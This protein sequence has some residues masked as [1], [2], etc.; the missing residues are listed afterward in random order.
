MSQN[1]FR[2]EVAQC[3]K[4]AKKVCQN[5][6][7]I[8]LW[9]QNLLLQSAED[10]FLKCRS[11]INSA[12][13]LFAF[14]K[15]KLQVWWNLGQGL[16]SVLVKAPS[17]ILICQYTCIS[18]RYKLF[19]LNLPLS[20]KPIHHSEMSVNFP[21]KIDVSRISNQRKFHWWCLQFDW[22]PS[23]NAWVWILS[24]NICWV[25][26]PFDYRKSPHIPIDHRIEMKHLQ[27]CLRKERFSKGPYL[28]MISN[29]WRI[30]T[31]LIWL[32]RKWISF[33]L[34]FSVIGIISKWA[35]FEH[36]T[37]MFLSSQSQRKGQNPL[38]KAKRP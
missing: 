18:K 5:C 27:F 21:L 15:F 9:V 37:F 7:S 38:A 6:H 11:S 8:T 32:C 4:R 13:I 22:N 34:G 31:Y 20:K 2:F 1:C 33:M 24:Q 14:E 30:F 25:T 10:K 26:L 36:I 17:N 29:A 35:S 28:Q 19:D 16:V 3:M 12:K 23:A